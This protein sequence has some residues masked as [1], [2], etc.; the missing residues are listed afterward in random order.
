MVS[1]PWP[2][3]GRG[4]EQP[5]RST[6]CNHRTLLPTHLVNVPHI[7]IP[8]PRTH[9]PFDRPLLRRP[10]GDHDW[11]DSG[12]FL[13]ELRTRTAYPFP[14]TWH[15]TENRQTHGN[16]VAGR[17]EG[18]KLGPRPLQEIHQIPARPW[19]AGFVGESSG[20]QIDSLPRPA[21]GPPSTDASSTPPPF[22]LSAEAP[23]G[24]VDPGYGL[25]RDGA[26]NGCASVFRAIS[27]HLLVAVAY[28]GLLHSRG[29]HPP[30][31]P[32]PPLPATALSVFHV[33]FL[34]LFVSS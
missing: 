12:P 11:L 29:C 5:G 27:S 1:Q 22:C 17:L 34:D 18:V 6:T 7:L 14:L 21:D 31:S 19:R 13:Q 9:P 15:Y 26:E 32:S 25:L 23:A 20:G 2:A 10:I 30:W 33:L 4:G 16:G 28:G 24:K 8:P 3:L